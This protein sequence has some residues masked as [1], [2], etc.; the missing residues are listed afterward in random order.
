[1]PYSTVYKLS[2]S[3]IANDGKK[4]QGFRQ[5]NNF[6][7]AMELMRFFTSFG[8][9]HFND[10]RVINN[11]PWE[12]TAVYKH[13]ITSLIPNDKDS[14]W[15]GVFIGNY[16]KGGHK[17]DLDLHFYPSFEETNMAS[18]W[19]Q[20]LFNTVNI[21][22][23]SGQ[24][25]PRFF[26]N[27]TLEVE[28]E[29]PEGIEDPTLVFTSTG[30]GGWGGGNMKLLYIFFI[31]VFMLQFNLHSQQLSSDHL[32][33]LVDESAPGAKLLKDAGLKMDPDTLH[34]SGQGT[35]AVFFNFNNFYLE[36]LWISHKGEAEKSGN[37]IVDMFRNQKKGGSPFGF[38][39]ARKSN[40]T[41]W[42]PFPN[43]SMYADWIRP[44]ESVKFGIS[45]DI[46]LPSV[47][48]VPRY[49]DSIL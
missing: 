31:G 20:P 19:I 12:E 41:D 15:I 16:D 44:D 27:D 24:Q 8:A 29:I 11:Y 9:G 5:E 17:I 30:H 42:L 1:M 34:H 28:F 13:D 36:L 49:L 26:K 4:Y 22:E 40:E 46:M 38:V 37:K 14:I 33:I 32:F 35:S 45:N 25:Y 39:V 23:M 43:E 21:M 47:I 6:I 48:V 10:K 2:P 3:F 7:P 18:K